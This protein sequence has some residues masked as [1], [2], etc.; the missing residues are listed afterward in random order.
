[1][2]VENNVIYHQ[3]LDSKKISND[4]TD[5]LINNGQSEDG[6]KILQTAYTNVWRKLAKARHT[7]NMESAFIKMG[8]QKMSTH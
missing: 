1:M 7:P 8:Q 4:I 5:T 3:N 6:N 2:V